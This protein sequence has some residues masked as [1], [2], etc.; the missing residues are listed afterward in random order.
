MND[1][2]EDYVLKILTI[3][4]SG[5]GKT[6]L[7]LRYTED[8]F[9]KNHLTTIGIDYKAKNIEINQKNVKLKIWDTA[10]QERF[11]NITQQYYKSA[12]GILMVFDLTDKESFEKVKEWMKQIKDHNHNDKMVVVLVGN[13]CDSENRIVTNQEAE[14]LAKELFTTRY[15]ETSALQNIN[16]DNTFGYLAEQ[17]IS[18]KEKKE[19][20]TKPLEEKT[21]NLD[22]AT[23]DKKS[24]KKKNCC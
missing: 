22:S 11:R 16:I 8:R 15:Q 7:L 23:G 18:K 17:I 1:Q 14:S 21:V 24:Q 6:C 9:V 10:G 12:D 2:K 20:L 13:K 4:E 5:V 3:G 19:S